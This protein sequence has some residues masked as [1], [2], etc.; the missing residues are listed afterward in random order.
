MLK[1]STCIC[2]CH[3]FPREGAQGEKVH[4]MPFLYKRNY[5]FSPRPSTYKVVPFTAPPSERTAD[6]VQARNMTSELI[7]NK[8]AGSAVLGAEQDGG[9]AAAQGKTPWA[10]VHWGA[11]DTGPEGAATLQG[12]RPLPCRNGGPVCSTCSPPSSPPGKPG[13]LVLLR[14]LPVV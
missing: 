9:K 4:S 5:R 6:H 10:E 1:V 3:P 13:I 7:A 8:D 12:S 2:P 11:P 14:N